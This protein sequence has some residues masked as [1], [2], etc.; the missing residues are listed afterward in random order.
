MVIRFLLGVVKV[1]IQGLPV[2]ACFLFDEGRM[3]I[4]GRTLLRGGMVKRRMLTT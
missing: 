3:H 4:R 1:I 2:R